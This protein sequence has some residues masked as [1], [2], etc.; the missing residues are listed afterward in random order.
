MDIR[1][2]RDIDALIREEKRLS[3]CESQTETWAEGLSAGIEPEIMAEAALSTAFCEL[4]RDS[5]EE[6]AIA[7]IERMRERILSGE[8]DPDRCWH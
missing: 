3:A 2:T 5:S 6:A 7:L 4:L 1:E 8:F